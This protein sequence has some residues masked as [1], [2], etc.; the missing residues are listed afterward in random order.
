MKRKN[1][2]VQEDGI[3]ANDAKKLIE[4]GFN[5]LEAISYICKKI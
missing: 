4:P 1:K 3:N 5:S 2:K